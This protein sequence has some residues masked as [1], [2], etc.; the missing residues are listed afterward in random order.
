[1][2][3]ELKE[4]ERI[5]D[6]QLNNLK[7]I[8][9]KDGFCFGIDS[10]LLADF[11]KKIKNNST[12]IDFGT[13]TG[14]IPI[15][16]SAKIKAQHMIGIEIQEDIAEMA[17]RSVKLNGLENTISII[18]EDIRNTDKILET[19]KPVDVIVT[20]PPY[21]KNN[22]GLKNE[23]KIKQISRHEIE[24]NIEDIAR[25][26]KKILKE[27]GS[28]YMVHR[29]DR[30]VDIMEIF[31]KYKIEVKELRMVHSKESKDANLILIKAVKNANP[32]LKIHNPL[33]VYKNDGT[34][35]E[36]ILKIYNKEQK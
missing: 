13:G 7:L 28:I 23:N 9:K 11:A 26:A 10:V 15:L 21:M 22:S 5:D 31:R 17:I 36:E 14:I 19:V 33:Y 6:L 4:N 24:C 20:N 34:Y 29:P 12:I 1:M 18:K 27:N 2:N 3:I 32:F 30:L 8:Q 16:L 25:A 35:T